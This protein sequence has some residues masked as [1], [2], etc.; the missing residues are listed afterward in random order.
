MLVHADA[1][2]RSQVIESYTFTVRYVRDADN[3]QVPAGIE[4]GA[5]GSEPVT[6]GA[7]SRTLQGLIRQIN[8]LC[9][10]LPQLPSKYTSRLMT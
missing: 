7:V 6:T 3:Q 2:D 8:E 5:S 10:P 4:V 9:E 1:Q